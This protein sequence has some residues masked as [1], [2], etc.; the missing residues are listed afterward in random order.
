MKVV[1]IK[2]QYIRAGASIDQM[3]LRKLARNKDRNV[4]RRVAENSNCPA[5]LLDVLSTDEDYEVRIA[6]AENENCPPGVLL[7]LVQD[8]CTDVRYSMAS[9]PSWKFAASATELL[10][11]LQEDENPYVAARA[12][13][14]T[15]Y[16]SPVVA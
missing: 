7:K 8:P 5:D 4:R 2:K 14:S 6:V 12:L 10:R 16:L 13:M 3:V 1:G 9:F 11:M 15:S